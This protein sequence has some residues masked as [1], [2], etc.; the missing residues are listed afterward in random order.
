MKIRL[1]MPN[2]GMPLMPKAPPSASKAL[3]AA[4]TM[5][6]MARVPKAR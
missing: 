3:M 2:G 5:S 6:N 4:W 1:P